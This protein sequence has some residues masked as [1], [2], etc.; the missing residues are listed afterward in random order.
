MKIRMSR[1]NFI[2]LVSTVLLLAAT[3]VLAYLN[4][5]DLALKKELEMNSEFLLTQGDSSSIVTMAELLDLAP[6]EFEAVM[7]TSVTDPTP[8]TFTGVELSKICASRGLEITPNSILQVLA[9]DGYASV[10]TGAEVLEPGNV[11]IC[12]AMNGEALKP[13]A[14]GGFGPYLMVIKNVMF[15]QRWC[16]YVEEIVVR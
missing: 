14:Q 12:I 9:L 16:K 13:K 7:D 11:Y 2:V 10:V 8:V 1:G 4:A 5:G 6:V 3:A 15:S